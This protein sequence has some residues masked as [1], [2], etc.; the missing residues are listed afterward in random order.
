MPAEIIF[1]Q[2]KGHQGDTQQLQSSTKGNHY[3]AMLA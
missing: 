1:H 3:S 2:Q